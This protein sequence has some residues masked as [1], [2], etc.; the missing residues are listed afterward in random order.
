MDMRIPYEIDG[1]EV[2]KFLGKGKGGYSY[3]VN[4]ASGEAVLKKMHFE[5]C[6]I[7]SFPP[8]KLA[9]ELRDYATLT[10][11]NIPVPKLLYYNSEK[12]YLIKEYVDGPTCAELVARGELPDFCC[13][14][15]GS[16]CKSLYGNHLNIDY[17]PHNFVLKDTQLY[18]VD[19]ECN[20][21]SEAWDFEH[22][23]VFFWVNNRGMAIQ[24]RTGSHYY[25]SRNGKP[26]MNRSLKEKAQNV[27]NSMK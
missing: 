7:Y 5:K 6:D 25:L 9:V 3:L 14:Q 19:Y 2:L 15:I 26:L 20:P 24:L 16:M 10:K 27:L 1:I 12:Q 8:D 22:W 23:G 21:Y 17:M 13:Q 18:Y 4:Y 11:L